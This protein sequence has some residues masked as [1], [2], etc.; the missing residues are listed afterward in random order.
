MP[1]RGKKMSY[2]EKLACMKQVK[3]KESGQQIAQQTGWSIWTVRKGSHP[4]LPG[5]ARS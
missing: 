3:A 1:R 5:Q 2:A 4:W